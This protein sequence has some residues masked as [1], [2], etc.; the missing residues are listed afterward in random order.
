MR[1]RGNG[2]VLDEIAVGD[3]SS[4]KT[5]DG[6]VEGGNEDLGVRDEC[7]SDIDVAGSDCWQLVAVVGG[8]DPGGGYAF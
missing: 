7:S 8:V 4:G 1:L 6:T 3:E 2:H 5:D